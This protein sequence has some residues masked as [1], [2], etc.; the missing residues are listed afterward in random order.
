MSKLELK[1]YEKINK[2]V[3]QIVLL[4]AIWATK[5]YSFESKLDFLWYLGFKLEDIAKITGRTIRFIR[6]QNHCPIC[7]RG[8][9][10]PL[11]THFYLKHSQTTSTQKGIVDE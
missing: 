2:K 10:L 9:E 4:T 1:R 6:T 7:K 11:R 5:G 8:F 3:D